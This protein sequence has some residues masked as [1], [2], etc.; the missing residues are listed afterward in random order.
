MKYFRL[1]VVSLER[2]GIGGHDHA[3]RTILKVDIHYEN[4][5]QPPHTLQITPFYKLRAHRVLLKAAVTKGM[6]T[7]WSNWGDMLNTPQAWVQLYSRVQG[8]VS[9]TPFQGQRSAYK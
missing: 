3:T 1:K 4:D 5:L 9:T 7:G 2:I 8:A 6:K